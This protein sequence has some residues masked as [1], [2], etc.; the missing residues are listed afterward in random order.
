MVADVS[1]ARRTMDDG[2]GMLSL[3]ARTGFSSSMAER[4]CHE[5]ACQRVVVPITAHRA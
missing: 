1:P 3:P 2:W 5:A 4:A